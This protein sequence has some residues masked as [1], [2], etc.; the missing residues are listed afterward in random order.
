M[1]TTS[2]KLTLFFF[3]S[4]LAISTALGQIDRASLKG[5]VTDSSGAV[6]PNAVVAVVFPQTGF[7]QTVS[8]TGAGE[9]VFTGLPLGSCDLT[10]SSDGFAKRRVDHIVLEVGQVRTADVQLGLASSTEA[11]VVNASTVTMNKDDATVG[12]VIDSMQ[13]QNLPINGRNWAAL[14]LL[15]PGAINTGSGNQL[16]IRFAGRAIDDNKV[17]FDGVDAT[18]ILRQSQKLD[19]RVQISSESIAEFRAL[20]TVYPAQYGGTTGGQIDV[21]SRTG[22]KI[23]MVACTSFSQ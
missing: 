6:V 3:A 18:G 7:Q 13:V 11:V 14:E 21:V 19:L 15:V 9:Y 5:T 4:M 1:T 23:C 8:S 20:S 16:T 22:N 2:G 12:G 17:T 10:V